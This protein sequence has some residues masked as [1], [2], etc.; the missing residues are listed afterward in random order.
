MIRKVCGMKYPENMTG[1][2][3]TGANV[4]GLIFYEGSPRYFSGDLPVLPSELALAGV[5]VNSALPEV[6]EKTSRYRLSFIQLHGEE[7]PEYC[8][9]LSAELKNYGYTADIIKAIPLA[10]TGDLSIA[11]AYDGLVQYFLFDTKGPN[12]G[13]NGYRFNWDI[14]GGYELQT[15]FI[16]SGGIGPDDAEAVNTFL[17]STPGKHCSGFDL[18]SCFEIRPGLKNMNLIK[19]FNTRITGTTPDK[20]ITE[21]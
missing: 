1:L 13:G 20:K 21:I 5:F 6:I 12:K 11:E 7:S 15:P 10:G 4:M 2:A 9:A 8:K 17:G 16:L 14:L 19:E 18:N 3:G